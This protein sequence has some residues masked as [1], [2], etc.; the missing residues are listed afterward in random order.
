MPRSS[1]GANAIR[2]ARSQ[3]TQ[4]QPSSE[5]A[6]S[7][8]MGFPGRFSTGCNLCRRRKVKRSSRGSPVLPAS[9]PVKSVNTEVVT[10]TPVKSASKPNARANPTIIPRRLSFLEEHDS[11]CY[12]IN[13]FV[14]PPLD[15]AFPGYL[16]FVPGLYGRDDDGPFELATLAAARMVA[17][18]RSGNQSLRRQSYSDYG[19]AVK[20]LRLS[21]KRQD[22]AMSDKTI[23]TVLLLCLFLDFADDRLN[24]LG[25]HLSGLY[26]L[27]KSRGCYQISTK[28]S[29]ELLLVALSY[30]HGNIAITNDWAHADIGD[31]SFDGNPSPIATPLIHAVSL[32]YKEGLWRKIQHCSLLLHEF[33]EWDLYAATYWNLHFEK[34][35][36][37]PSLGKARASARHYDAKTASTV[38]L[39]RACRI[40][41]SAALLQFCRGFQAI[42]SGSQVGAIH[43]LA[44]VVEI[45]LEKEIALAISDMHYCMPYALGRLDDQGCTKSTDIDTAAGKAFA[46]RGP[47]KLIVNCSVA[48][49]EQRLQSQEY[50]AM[51]SEIAGL[52]PANT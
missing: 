45:K 37:P 7:V 48:R 35:A 30:L 14:C 50:L 23:G 1:R 29:F 33:D 27:L 6:F 38:V 12:F 2:T 36:A 13:R 3:P 40:Q 22:T 16:N 11:L 24:Q 8:I 19:A 32:A 49:E 39:L 15:P 10:A 5:L 9:L 52:R 26:Y 4:Q 25:T 17:Y 43:S 44:S 47:V 41:F 51:I 46:V 21:L 18:N 34:A 31:I 28:R 20:Q 42:E